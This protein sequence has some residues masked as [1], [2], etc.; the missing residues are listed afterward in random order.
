M[1]WGGGGAL[2]N[3]PG[4]FQDVEWRLATTPFLVDSLFI[5]EYPLVL[6]KNA[7]LFTFTENVSSVPQN[8]VPLSQ[9]NLSSFNLGRFRRKVSPP[10]VQLEHPDVRFCLHINGQCDL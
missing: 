6:K 9:G 2:R 1:V 7:M 3:I 5:W 10:L 8:H 4:L